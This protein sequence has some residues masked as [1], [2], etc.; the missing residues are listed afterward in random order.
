MR[1]ITSE[2]DT[3][4]HFLILGIFQYKYV[5]AH[6]KNQFQPIIKGE[7]L[8]ILSISTIYLLVSYCEWWD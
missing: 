7:V 6:L 8:D 3:P 5:F 2:S 4:S 1:L